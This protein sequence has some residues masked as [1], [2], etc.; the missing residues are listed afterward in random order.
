MP[1]FPLLNKCLQ[2]ATDKNMPFFAVI[3]TDNFAVPLLRR[4]IRKARAANVNKV[5]IH[6]AVDVLK[7]IEKYRAMHPTECKLPD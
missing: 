7:S 4:W 3:A 5:K 6:E 2:K 1:D